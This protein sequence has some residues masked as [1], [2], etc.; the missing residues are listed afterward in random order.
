MKRV[1]IRTKRKQKIA[2]RRKA[3]GEGKPVISKYAAKHMP[4]D[5]EVREPR[6]TDKAPGGHL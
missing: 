5:G 3:R 6:P 4:R 2:D 1:K